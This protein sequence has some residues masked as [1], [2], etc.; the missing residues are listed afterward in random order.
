MNLIKNNPYRILGL[1]A[2]ASAREQQ[3]Q[4]TRLIQFIGA[5]QE[6]EDDFSFSILGNLNR[7]VANVGDAASKLNLESD[8]INAAL[9][10]FINGNEITDQP[11]FDALKDGSVLEAL[12]IWSKLIDVNDVSNKNYS[13]FLNLSTYKLNIAF[14]NV[15]FVT[16]ALQE[17]ITLKLKFLESDLL[18]E[19]L[20]KIVGITY[21]PK[22]EDLQKYFLTQIQFE[23]DKK[24][25]N[26]SDKF[27]DIITQIEFSGKEDFLKEFTQKP[28][29]QIE[30]R[31]N[32]AKEQR[33]ANKAEAY[34]TGTS[35]YADT[36]DSLT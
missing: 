34:N 3:R 35:L 1:L 25:Q 29:Q 9:F 26:A 27:L 23:L 8:K 17:G 16:S 10:W 20:K 22:K 30:R 28:I 5:D 24:E 21:K 36:L 19:F 7:T 18:S 6:P 15:P 32:E 14:S 31:I 33:K 13:A 11:A 12:N 2:G 4:T